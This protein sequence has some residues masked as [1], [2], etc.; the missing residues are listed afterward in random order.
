[1]KIEN[2]LNNL[3]NQPENV[4]KRILWS[5]VS[6][7]AIILIFFWWFFIFQKTLSNLN[8]ENLEKSFNIKGLEEKINQ[9]K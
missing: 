9:L 7:V 1:M 4:K 6:I 2:F 3:R 5:V 8:K